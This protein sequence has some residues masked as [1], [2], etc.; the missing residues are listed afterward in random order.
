MRKHAQIKVSR[1]EAPMHFAPPAIEHEMPQMSR[2]EKACVTAVL[3]VLIMA[4]GFCIAAVQGF[5][6]LR[7]F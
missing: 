6:E 5:A 2:A 1:Q 4:V 7:G 3:F